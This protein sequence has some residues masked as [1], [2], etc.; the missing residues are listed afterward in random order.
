MKKIIIDKD[1]CIGCGACEGFDSEI[2][3]LNDEGLATVKKGEFDKL[4]DEEK[5]TA[6][7]AV[8]SCPT[9][10]IAITELEEN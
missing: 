1:K 8:S 10:A 9:S 4:S 3:E 5:E 6:E 2:F 7:D